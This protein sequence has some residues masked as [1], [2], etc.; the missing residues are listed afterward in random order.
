MIHRFG[1][2]ICFIGAL[3]SERFPSCP[4]GVGAVFVVAGLAVLDEEDDEN[5]LA[6]E[7][8]QSD[9]NPDAAAAGVVKPSETEGEA[10]N[11]ERKADYHDENVHNQ[12]DN[13]N[14]R[15]Q[16]LNDGEDELDDDG[17]QGVVPVFAAPCPS[18]KV[19]VVGLQYA[20]DRGFE[21]HK[22]TFSQK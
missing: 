4:F 22:I 17:K 6:D 15:R 3:L 9:K 21:I 12:A 13:G 1:K 18:V 10:G 8:N 14:A 20:C 5:N 16:L 11:E 19:G 2:H 7:R